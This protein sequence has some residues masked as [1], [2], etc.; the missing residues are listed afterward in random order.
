MKPWTIRLAAIAAALTL[1]GCTGGTVETKTEDDA[2]QLVKQHS[3]QVAGL[4]GT[5]AFSQNTESPG[6]CEGKLGE[7]NRDIFSV[8]GAYMLPVEPAKQLDTLAR[9]RE[10][11]KADGFTIAEDRVIAQ[12][13]GVLRATTPDG[14]SLRLLS[15]P[16]PTS[17][18]ILI[19]SPCYKSPTAR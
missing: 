9:I 17:L 11:W 6:P 1:A 2:K 4:I 14:F 12:N 5:T 7:T 13:R 8:Q 18:G 3:E 19:H 10:A 16:T 15:T